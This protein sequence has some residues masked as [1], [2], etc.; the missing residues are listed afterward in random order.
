MRVI[1]AGREHIFRIPAITYQPP[2]VIFGK[3]TVKP[4]ACKEVLNIEGT[5]AQAFHV[6][7]TR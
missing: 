6:I 5:N 2:V 1:V 7:S 3:R 4:K